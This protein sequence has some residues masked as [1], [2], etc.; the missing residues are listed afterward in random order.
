MLKSIMNRLE[1]DQDLDEDTLCPADH[2]DLF[3]AVGYGA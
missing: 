3:G 2:F 1:Y